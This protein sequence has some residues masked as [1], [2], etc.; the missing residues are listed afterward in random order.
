M[1]TLYA[2]PDYQTFDDANTH[3]SLQE[4]GVDIKSLRD[5]EVAVRASSAMTAFHG[6]V[7]CN[8]ALCLDN[9]EDVKLCGDAISVICQ[10]AKHLENKLIQLN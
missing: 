6:G 1:S 4:I 5:L 9:G 7:D 8:Y 2:Y 10:F 3:H